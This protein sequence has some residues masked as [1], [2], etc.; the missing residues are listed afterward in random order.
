MSQLQKLEK[1]SKKMLL[2][3]SIEEDLFVLQDKKYLIVSDNQKLFLED[4]TFI[5]REPE[6]GLDFDGYVYEFGGRWYLQ[7]K[8][9]SLSLTELCYIGEAKQKIP[10]KSFLGIH[11]GY[12][13][14][15]GVGLYK[16]WIKKAKFLGA[17]ALAICEKS[18][19]SGVLA[20]QSEC[21][22]KKIKAIIGM[23][24]PVIDS[25]LKTYEV[26]L[27]VK[28]F[29]GWLNLLKINSIL[30]VENKPNIEIDFL[31]QNKDGLF[32]IADPKTM[33]YSDST[34][35]HYYQLDTVRYRERDKDE[36]YLANL[37]KFILSN[38]QPISIYDAYCLEERDIEVREAL[39][40]INKGYDYRTFNQYFKNRDNYIKELIELF[41][42]GNSSWNKLYK[43]ASKNE[44]FLVENCN[45]NY[46]TDTRHLPRYV[47]TEEESRMYD[48][49][50]KLFMGLIKE[51]FKK[52]GIKNP[53]KYLDRL[54]IEVEVL[55]MGD[56]ID[57]F[58]SLHDILRYAKKENILTGIG[59]GSAGGSLVAYLLG[60]I[61]VNP[62]EFDLLFERFLNSGRMGLWEDRPSYLIELKD[63]GSTIELAE[64]ALVR[65]IR[66][67]NETVVPIEDLKEDDVILRY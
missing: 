15:N 62:L 24:V 39:W 40:D 48:S 27:Y 7:I 43:V 31:K 57:Y 44:D 66:N 1:Y 56:V 23:T 35:F 2:D 6:S 55:K 46:D 36:W 67:N 20:F 9:S 3:F 49:N 22:S 18:T 29:N 50:F 21:N 8:G 34:L 12:E 47:M 65:I 38:L 28:D 10:M 58:L 59:R 16:D 30:N 52:R 63:D 19:L 54:K 4:L 26:K 51:G 13:L 45:F 64:G 53:K 33:D 17:K 61:Q 60:I 32:I 14:M 5:D 41:E 37:K 25:D 42:K 11:S